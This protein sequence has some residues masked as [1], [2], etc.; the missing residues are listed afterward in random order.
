MRF[1]KDGLAIDTKGAV[2]TLG[3]SEMR[4][5][6]PLVLDCQALVRKVGEE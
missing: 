1:L 3:Q 2:A 5:R 6:I 4:V